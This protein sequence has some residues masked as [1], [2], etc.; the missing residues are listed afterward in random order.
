MHD[1]VCSLALKKRSLLVIISFHKQW[2][3]EGTIESS[4]VV[5]NLNLHVLGKAPCSVEI[6]IDH[7]HM[8]SSRSL[9]PSTLLYCVVVL[10]FGG[11]DDREALSYARRMLE[12]QNITL[13]AIQF[14]SRDGGEVMERMLRYGCV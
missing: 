12:Q 13:T 10:F 6:L 7:R 5:R 2:L 9:L 4:N 3:I 14:S 1:D 8:G 11:A